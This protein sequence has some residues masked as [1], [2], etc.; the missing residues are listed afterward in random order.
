[1]FISHLTLVNFMLPCSYSCIISHLIIIIF[2]QIN[3]ARAV[4]VAA[5]SAAT[6]IIPVPVVG[7]V[8][9]AGLIARTITVYYEQLGLVNITSDNC[10][11]SGKYKD[12]LGKF[13]CRSTGELISKLAWE[14][15]AKLATGEV[16]NYI[17]FI[18]LAIAGGISFGFTLQY[19]LRCIQE[20]EVVAL[21]VWDKAAE[22][23]NWFTDTTTW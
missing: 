18:G 3:I 16:A 2:W 23:H 7:A 19:L 8:I 21:A 5:I 20:L 13:F 4:V 15:G 6:G 1:M 9:D 14:E 17:P 12:V 22:Q 10:K 11:L